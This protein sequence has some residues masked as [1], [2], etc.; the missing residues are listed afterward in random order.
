MDG[1]KHSRRV[2]H[3]TSDASP[4]TPRGTPGEGGREHDTY[5]IEMLDGLRAGDPRSYERLV[6]A[7]G[8]R[9]LAVARRILGNEDDAR[10]CIQ[11]AFLQVF[12]S[13]DRFEARA[14]LGSWLHRIVVN[15][16]LMKL[17]SRASR[18]E[19][20]VDDLTPEFD[21][22][23]SRVEER[24]HL[25]PAET[26]LARRETRE[27]VRGAIARL[28]DR[29]RA[30]LVLRDIEGYDTDESGRLL[31]MTPTAVRTSL[32]RARAALKRILEPTMRG[33]VP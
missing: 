17:R 22:T 20:L 27:Y 1:L 28:P 14:S 32:H 15:A 23:G 26:I 33:E 21:E 12:K 5:E 8:G 10:E 30:V 9:A 4:P 24:A 29:Y 31:G 3:P 2:A 6:R 11:E 16:A 13:I 25:L 18:P 19:T 7:H